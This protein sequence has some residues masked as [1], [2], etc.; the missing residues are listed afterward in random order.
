MGVKTSYSIPKMAIWIKQ[1]S[2][3]IPSFPIVFFKESE[4]WSS[5]CG[6]VV[7]NLTSIL[8]DAGLIPGLAQ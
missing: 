1:P 5:H 6:S 7:T 3:Q 4:P 2:N 8:D